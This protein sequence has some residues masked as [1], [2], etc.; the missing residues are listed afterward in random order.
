MNND[1]EYRL[2]LELKTRGPMTT[3]Q[4]ADILGLTS[5]GARRQLEAAT[6]DGLVCFAEHA[7]AKGRPARWWSLTEAAHGRFPDRHSDLLNTLFTHIQAQLG[8]AAMESI[9]GAREQDMRTQYADQLS[10][11]H[12]L[13]DKVMAL[14]SLRSLE[15]YMAEARPDQSD[16]LLIEHHCPI[17][18]AARACQSFCRSELALFR[19]LL[20]EAHVERESHLLNDG[21]RCVYRISPISGC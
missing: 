17:C 8:P 3:Q 19:D 21:Q 20:P 10:G 18:A 13:G 1:L 11:Q 14:A 9:I 5:M 4:L 12:T 16:W 15:G 7:A 6:A 2:L